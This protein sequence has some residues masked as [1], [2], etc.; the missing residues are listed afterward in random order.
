MPDPLRDQLVNAHPG[1]RR[2]KIKPIFA[3]YDLWV[4]VFIDRPKRRVYIFPIPMFGLVIE[5]CRV[6]RSGTPT[7]NEAEKPSDQPPESGEQ[8]RA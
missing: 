4:G 3:W 1:K 6:E 2:W 8:E 7:P 5:R